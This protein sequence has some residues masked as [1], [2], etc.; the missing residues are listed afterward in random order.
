MRIDKNNCSILLK[1]GEI[2]DTIKLL[3]GIIEKLICNNNNIKKNS[4]KNRIRGLNLNYLSETEKLTDKELSKLHIKY[5]ESGDISL[6]NKLVMS[7]SYIAQ[8]AAMQLRC[9]ASTQIQ[10]EDM[11]NQ[12]IITLI[13]CMDR[14]DPA[15]GIKFDTYAFIRVKGGIIDFIRK[16][17]WVPRGIRLNSKR[18][19]ETYNKLYTELEREPTSEEIAQKMGI[20]VERLEKYNYEISNSIVY[21]F[22]ELIQN[23]SH[24]GNILESSTL[25]DITPEN[26]LLKT[27]MRRILK[28]SIDELSERERTIITLY[29]FDNLSLAEIAKIFHVSIQRISQINT[30]AVTKLKNKMNSYILIDL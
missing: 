2:C 20:S 21:S 26:K 6:R 5:K 24:V 9:S 25:V 12:G 8:I 29:Y 3:L 27:E 1:F 7:Y 11:I 28:D 30:R 22:E 15:K 23:V 10:V 4:R 19:D 16:Q 14:F 13:D 17:D 18:I